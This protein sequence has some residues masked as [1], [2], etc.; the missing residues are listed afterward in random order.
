[1][2]DT[3]TNNNF[4]NYVLD[5]IDTNIYK[6]NQFTPKKTHKHICIVKFGNKSLEAIRLQEIINQPDI[7]KSLPYDLQ[8]KKSIP[9]V[10]Y[11]LGYTV[12]NL[13]LNYKDVVNSIQFD[14]EVSPSLNINL[15]KK[16]KIW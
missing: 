1:M 11:K 8:E 16:N 10:I 2:L 6:S 13:V 3:N 15:C 7:R 12:R 9:T 4:Y 5:V 14:E